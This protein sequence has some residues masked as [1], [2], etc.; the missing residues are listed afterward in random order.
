VHIFEHA[1]RR[2]RSTTSTAYFFNASKNDPPRGNLFSSVHSIGYGP[3]L[4]GLAGAAAAVITGVPDLLEL[5]AGSA[6]QSTGL[7]HALWCFT[8]AS[9]GV[10]RTNAAALIIAERRRTSPFHSARLLSGSVKRAGPAP[11]S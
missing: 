10:R 5:P 1:Q 11:L 6:A 9:A 4:L 3:E 7:W 2:D 8:I